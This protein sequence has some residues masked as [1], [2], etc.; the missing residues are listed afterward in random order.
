MEKVNVLIQQLEILL[1]TNLL[2]QNYSEDL[3]LEIIYKFCQ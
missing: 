1:M 3:Y 2:I